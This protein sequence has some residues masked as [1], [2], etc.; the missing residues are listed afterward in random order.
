MTNHRCWVA[1]VAFLALGTAFAEENLDF[2]KL[3]VDRQQTLADLDNA[4][5]KLREAEEESRRVAANAK[6]IEA[7]IDRNKVTIE[8]ARRRLERAKQI[9]SPIAVQERL[10]RELQDA[11]ASTERAKRDLEDK[12]R[13]TKSIDELRAAIRLYDKKLSEIETSING[14]LARD[15]VAQQFKAQISL[16]FAIVVG[17]MILGFFGIAFTDAVVRNNIFSGDSGIQFVTLFS[18][19]IAIILFGITGILGDK[20]LA[21]LLGGLSG[22]I[23]GK[24]GNNAKAGSTAGSGTTAQHA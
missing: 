18:L 17:L 14:L 8:D 3:R 11:E 6:D 2:G 13:A 22:Y 7:F 12:Q 19:I 10:A 16:Y 5:A 23:L 9:K 4:R 24:Y 15:V 1:V 21:A 20:E